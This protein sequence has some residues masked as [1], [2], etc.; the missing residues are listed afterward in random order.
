M[1]KVSIASVDFG[2]NVDAL[3]VLIKTAIL[4]RSSEFRVSPLVFR[5]ARLVL[6]LRLRFLFLLGEGKLLLTYEVIDIGVT[7]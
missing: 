1:I 5:H 7:K 2:E 4:F 3:Y 6:L